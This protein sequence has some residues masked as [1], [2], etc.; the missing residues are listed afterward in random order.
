MRDSIIEEFRLHGVDVELLSPTSISETE[1]LLRKIIVHGCERLVVAG[2]DGIINLAI[3]ILAGSK[4]ILGIIPTGSGNDFAR[5]LNLPLGIREATITALSDPS[6][7][8]LLKV[9]ERWVASVLTFGFSADVNTRANGMKRPKG[10]S[11]Y[12]LATLLSLPDLRSRPVHMVIDGKDHHFDLTLGTVANT[13]DFGGGMQI[14]PEADPTDGICNLTLVTDIG[15]LE[16][17]RFFR[18]VFD[19]SHMNHPKVQSLSGREIFFMTEGFELWGDGERI[20]TSPIRIELV[21]HALH[22]A[23]GSV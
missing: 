9:G 12:T 15:K 5:A 3:Q 16:L 10:P 19:G 7:L 17:L 8:D 22:L 14:A 1:S 13:S 11:R 2:G 4:T 18:R 23:R 21:S 6:S 20:G